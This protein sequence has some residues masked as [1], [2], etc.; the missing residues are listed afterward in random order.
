MIDPRS[1]A[2]LLQ[3]DRS[4]DA[5]LSPREL[6]Q[7]PLGEGAVP[8]V[9]NP[10]WESFLVRAVCRDG[11]P[12]YMFLYF[13]DNR[14]KMVVLH[15]AVEPSVEEHEVKRLHEAWLRGFLGGEPPYRY[16]WGSVESEYDPRSDSSDVIITYGEPE[17]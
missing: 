11:T 14:L 4:L 3:G 17:P 8:N 13:R 1:G 10:P 2:L 16:D 15:H 9:F 6:F 7:T 12:V 5:S